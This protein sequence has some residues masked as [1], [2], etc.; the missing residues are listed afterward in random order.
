MSVQTWML[1]AAAYLATTLSPG[2][3]V[4]LVIR[5]TV[6]YGSRGTAATIAGNL[7]AQGVI[8]MLVALGVG[9][10]L[11][12]MPPLFVAMK[13]IGA[14]YLIFLGIRQLRSDRNRRSPD[15]N[16][17]IVEPD[18]RKLFREALFVS[19]SNPKTMIFMSAF[20]PQFIAHDRPLA[21]QFVVMYATIACTVVVVHS[22]YSFGVRRLHRGF[23]VSPWVRTAKRASGLLFVGLGIKL[24]TARQ[25]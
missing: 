22:V 21:M 19:G 15:G 14:A 12:A 3:N 24:L 4:L 6:R 1:F 17:A 5:N 11:A 18:R 13:V 9:A 20:M 16:T 8:V 25:A 10:V 7:V 2:P 23:G